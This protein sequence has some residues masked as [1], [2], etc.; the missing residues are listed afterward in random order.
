MPVVINHPI[1]VLSEQEFH[2]LDYRIMKLAFQTH[3]DLGRFYDEKIYQN[4][5]IE[6]CR[7]NNITIDSEVKIELM[8]GSFKKSLFIDLL[9]ESSF[10]YELKASKAIAASHRVQTLGYLFLTGTSHGKI[11]NF[12]LPSVEHEF[13]S[14]TLTPLARRDLFIVDDFDSGSSAAKQLKESTIELLRDWGAYLDTD[15][16]KEALC[17]LT[18]NG[19]D[20]VQ[21]V[22]IKSTTSVLGK[23]NIPLI[24]LEESFCVSSMRNGKGVYQTHLQRFLAHTPLK[25]LHWINLNNSTVEFK[26]LQT[27]SF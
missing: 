18:G 25:K 19:T 15:L 10:V 20:I 8:H 3:N 23:Q 7:E 9:I 12:R 14:T 24:G 5:L 26:T 16:Y 13:V 11:I 1:K 6:L 22:E 27:E 17:H 21:P 2:D 4:K